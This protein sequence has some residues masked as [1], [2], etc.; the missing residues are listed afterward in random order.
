MD[1]DERRRRRASLSRRARGRRRP[2]ESDLAGADDAARIG[3]RAR[4]RAPSPGAFSH[5]RRAVAPGVRRNGPR[6]AGRGCGRPDAAHR[7]RLS[8][9]FSVAAGCARARTCSNSEA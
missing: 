5:A 1:R 9:R 3:G 8:L 6:G 7:R 2:G 4:P